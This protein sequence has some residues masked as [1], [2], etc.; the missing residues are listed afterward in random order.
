MKMFPLILLSLLVAGQPSLAGDA[1]AQQSIIGQAFAIDGDTLVIEGKKLRMVGIDAPE[2]HQ[3]C[4]RHG[5]NW[6]CG[7]DSAAYLQK[8]VAEDV[9]VCHFTEIDKY[10]RPLVTCESRG[11]DINLAMVKSGMATAYHRY[12]PAAEIV[13]AEESAKRAHAGLWQSNFIQPERFRHGQ[14]E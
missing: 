1:P 11:Q 4:T 13:A 5:Q 6:A 2:L 12:H 14:S 8:L 9:T 7:Y 3:K 10:K